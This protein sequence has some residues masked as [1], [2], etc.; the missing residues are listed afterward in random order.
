MFDTAAFE[1][2]VQAHQERFLQEFGEAI[3]VPSVAAQKRG[4]KEMADLLT[5]RF[6]KLGAT[7]RQYPIDGGSPVVYA[8]IGAGPRTLLIYNH[9]DVQPE[10][11]VDLWDSDP[12]T[13]THRDGKLYG[14][15]VADD[16]GELFSRL[17]ALEAWLAVEKE[18]PLKIKWVMEGEEE[19][20]SV[21]LEAWVRQYADMLQADGILWEGG[22]YDEA[23]RITMSAGCKGIAYFELRAH[24]PSRDLH[25]AYAPIVTNPAWRLVY[26]LGTLKDKNDKITID[27]YARHVRALTDDQI[28]RIEAIPF[29]AEAFKANYGLDA[30]LNGMDADQAL[31]RL[32]EIPTVTICGLDSGYHGAGSKTILPATATAKVDCRLVPDLTPELVSDLLRRHLDKRGFTDIEIVLLGGERPAHS[33]LNSAIRMA[34][35]EASLDTWNQTPVLIPWTAGSGPM[36]PLSTMLDIPVISAGATWNPG[37]QIHSPNENI[38]ERDYFLNMRFLAHL[39]ERFSRQ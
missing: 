17:Q 3:A 26:A 11:P 36:Y 19:I 10:D 2:Y 5:K 24:G 9:Y 1:A 27:G 32:Y 38:V 7:V 37:N 39:I 4:L 16:K 8:E 25:S 14:R 34:A 13:L 20:G 23:G 29:E 22:G 18:L 30:F 15:G 6:R 12:F 28:Q 35:F 21:H 33:A 31:R